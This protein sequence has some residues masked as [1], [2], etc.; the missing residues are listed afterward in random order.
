MKHGSYLVQHMYV[1]NTE[2]SSKG[3]NSK[4]LSGDKYYT[5]QSVI[6]IIISRIDFSKV[7]TF[8]EPCA[9]GL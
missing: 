2:M 8:I 6:D 7:N 9:G 5:P 3:R 4:S 1:K